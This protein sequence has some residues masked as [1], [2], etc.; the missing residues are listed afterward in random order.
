MPQKAR[1]KLDSLKKGFLNWTPS[2]NRFF[3]AIGGMPKFVKIG[4]ID[5][6]QVTTKSNLVF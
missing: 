4:Q 6:S 2:L 1:I 3:T 5:Q